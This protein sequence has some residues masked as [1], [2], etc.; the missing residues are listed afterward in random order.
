MLILSFC[1][2]LAFSPLI[3]HIGL[4][5]LMKFSLPGFSGRITRYGLND[6]EIVQ[7][8]RSTWRCVIVVIVMHVTI[9]CM[10][11]ILKL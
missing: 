8:A 7:H 2:L 6:E 3:L 9:F 4:V 5:N 11:M 10:K 1:I